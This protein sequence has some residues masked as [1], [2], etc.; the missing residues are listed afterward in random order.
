MST[1][2]DLN[3]ELSNLQTEFLEYKFQSK[4]YEDELEKELSEKNEIISEYQE[5]YNEAIENLENLKKK[6]QINEAE[7]VK[8]QLEIDGLMKKLKIYEDQKQ[9]L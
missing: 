1:A 3:E 7:I 6:Y 5:K 2:E 8:L 4:E 9:E